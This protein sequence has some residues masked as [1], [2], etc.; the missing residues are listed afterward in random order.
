MKYIK[1][2][3]CIVEDFKV[4]T[5]VKNYYVDQ[6]FYTLERNGELEVRKGFCWDGASGA[7]DTKDF[8]VPSLVHD[9]F[10]VLVNRGILPPYAQALAD[11]Q[12][13][14][15][16]IESKM[17]WIRRMWTYI[18]VRLYQINKRPGSRAK[19]YEVAH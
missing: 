2:K 12:L 15:L 10:C 5:I 14:L 11:E 16:E 6:E 7:F 9:I 17:P 13:R 4:Q 1:T 19:V 8:M 3:Y 18:A